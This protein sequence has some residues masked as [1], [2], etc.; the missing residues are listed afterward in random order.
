MAAGGSPERR[1]A[2]AL[3]DLAV[4]EGAVEE[5]RTALDRLAA[6]LDPASVRALR[7]PSVTLARRVAAI[8][9]A[10]AGQPENVRALARLLVGR[11]RIALLPR[12]AA[13]FGQL[14]DERNGIAKAKIATAVELK[15][16]ERQRVVSRLERAT[17]KRIQA[18]FAVEPE[19][20]GGS[21]VRVGDRLI[22]ASLR[23][24]LEQMGREMAG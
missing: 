20:I 12:V 24:R 9:A 21:V 2:E 14:V 1:Y 3:L 22:D 23:S 19:L 7:D 10:T 17:G 13:A 5:H 16:A 8:E 6:S 4:A 18:T 11:D 15:D